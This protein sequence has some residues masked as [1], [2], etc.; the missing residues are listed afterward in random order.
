M[1]KGAARDKG[2]ACE[3][4]GQEI[5]VGLQGCFAPWDGRRPPLQCSQ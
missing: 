2:R 4:I 3:E 5:A 1:G